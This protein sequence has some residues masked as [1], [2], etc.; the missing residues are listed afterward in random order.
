MG[1]VIAVDMPLRSNLFVLLTYFIV[2]AITQVTDFVP[3]NSLQQY[4]ILANCPK[5]LLDRVANEQFSVILCD[6]ILRTA[7]CVCNT[8]GYPVAQSMVAAKISN[9]ID[10]GC[11]DTGDA[12][13]AD[14]VFYSWCSTNAAE[15]VAASYGIDVPTGSSS[16]PISV[17]ATTTP[18][19]P[20]STSPNTQTSIS[21][22]DRDSSDLS[23]GDIAGIAVAIAVFVGTVIVTVILERRRRAA[24]TSHYWLMNKMDHIY[25]EAV[26]RATRPFGNH[27]PRASYGSA[28]Q[29]LQEHRM[30]RQLEA[31]DGPLALESPSY[32]RGSQDAG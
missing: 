8:D 26:G 32:R 10:T 20:G 27:T 22:N 21:S 24:A 12:P 31:R 1:T 23:V 9:V 2:N 28:S 17:P 7:A 25:F 19:A 6:P 16:G 11:T 3:F 13:R 29:E 14:N 5:T 4:Q 30:T 15:A 18:T